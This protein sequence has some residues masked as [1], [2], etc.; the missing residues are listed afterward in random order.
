VADAH[1]G[2]GRAGRVQ[3]RRR[4]GKAAALR[5]AGSG[6]AGA[7][8][9]S[10]GRADPGAAPEGPRTVATG[11]AASSVAQRPRPRNPWN[12]RGWK[13]APEGRR[14]AWPRL[15]TLRCETFLR[16]SGA[17]QFILPCSTGSAAL[18]PWL[19]SAA[20]PGPVR[21]CS[22]P[23][24][25]RLTVPARPGTTG[26]GPRLTQP[27]QVDGH[28]GPPERAGERELPPA[29][30]V[31]RDGRDRGAVDGRLAER[32][33]QAD[34]RQPEPADEEPELELEP[35]RGR[36]GGGRPSARVAVAAARPLVRPDQ[37]ERRRGR[38][39]PSAPRG[40]PAWRRPAS[41][42]AG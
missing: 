29:V 10:R 25:C 22:P 4:A 17:G 7:A 1:A 5:P 40:R 6:P 12:G 34:P 9:E 18:H 33:D 23:P 11:G 2:F 39:R 38:A 27:V 36:R 13:P 32:L 37:R 30:G 19:Q 26:G 8:Q 21:A 42:P 15:S 28:A 20:P 16:P 14:E 3:E 35:G 31:E 41:P 24:P